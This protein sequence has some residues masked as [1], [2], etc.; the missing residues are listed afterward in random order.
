MFI[1]WYMGCRGGRYTG[2]YT[3]RVKLGIIAG[4]IMNPLYI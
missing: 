3:G 2:R 1:T 4:G